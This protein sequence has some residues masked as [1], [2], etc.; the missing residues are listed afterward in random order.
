MCKPDWRHRMRRRAYKGVDAALNSFLEANRFLE[1]KEVFESYRDASKIDAESVLD[2]DNQG[3]EMQETQSIN[4]PLET[5]SRNRAVAF[6]NSV[7]D[8]LI[9]KVNMNIQG[10]SVHLSGA[11]LI[12]PDWRSLRRR[13][14]A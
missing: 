7:P 8:D 3:H 14:Q 9:N 1:L 10:N 4:Q 12:L 2:D 13:S 11:F 6:D 5:A